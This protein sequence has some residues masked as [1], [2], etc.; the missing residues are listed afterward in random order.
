MTQSTRPL[1]FKS[2]GL[3]SLFLI[4][5]LL[6]IVYAGSSDS[7]ISQAIG[8]TWQAEFW[9]F[10]GLGEVASRVLLDILEAIAI[11]LLGWLFY[12]GFQNIQQSS[13]DAPKKLVMLWTILASGLLIFVTPFHSSDIFGYLNR[14]FQQSIFHTNPYLTTIAEI[15]DWQ[16]SHLLHAHWIDNPCPYG[17]FF[18]QLTHWLTQL[19]NAS[20]TNA[21]LIL[22]T[23]NLALI[24]GTTLL[25]AHITRKLNFSKPW[26]A[27]YLF[28]ANPLVLLHVMGNGHND[29]LMVFLLL[30]AVTCLQSKR[31]QWLCLPILTLSILTKY[32]SLL[33]LPFILLYLFKRKNYQALLT[34]SLLS[35]LLLGGLACSY[36]DPGQKWPWNALLDNAGKPQHSLISM[37]A[38]L[39]YY[40]LKWT[41]LPAQKITDQVLQFLKPL[42]WLGFIGF[43]GCRLWK[44]LKAQA[45]PEGLLYEIALTSTVMVAFIS[46]KF[47]P[48]YPI[49]FLPLTL[50]LPES[51]RLRQFSLIFCLFQLAGF[52]IFQNLPIASEAL[53][54]LVPVWLTCKRY[55]LFQTSF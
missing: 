10:P 50:L 21:Y 25:I 24:A 44:F 13:T 54:T 29:I 40:P 51:S 20:F 48:W 9:H 7:S 14:G 49:M 2:L 26:L 43:Y 3:Y 42:F 46:A 47:H 37:L 34:G 17:F 12:Q 19:A 22:K 18:A 15:P 23:L 52:T 33:A 28:G 31:I 39:V 27:A 30:L 41:P 35:L 32:A 45:T 4:P 36:V 38:E 5:T 11:A 53:L 8:G 16:N 55:P 6:L 1:L